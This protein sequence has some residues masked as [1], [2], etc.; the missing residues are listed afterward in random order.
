MVILFTLLAKKADRNN[1]FRK[2]KLSR[3]E[4]PVHILHT[5]GCWREHFCHVMKCCRNFLCEQKKR[6]MLWGIGRTKFWQ[7]WFVSFEDMPGYT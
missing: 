5:G 2:R 7:F 4:V 6:R 3:K 1:I